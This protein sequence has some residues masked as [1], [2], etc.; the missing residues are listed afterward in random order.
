MSDNIVVVI[1]MDSYSIPNDRKGDM[2]A[3]TDL[4][5]ADGAS[6]RTGFRHSSVV[7]HDFA[8][9]I[10][11]MRNLW[12]EPTPEM[13]QAGLAEQQ[14]I[15]DEWDDQGH[16]QLGH[17]NEPVSDDQASDAAV[18]ILQAMAEKLPKD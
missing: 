14:R 18:F 1:G 4:S 2:I 5:M 15:L 13:V 6:N 11:K 9:H 16:I 12:L 7:A 3:V 10:N 8:V 17:G